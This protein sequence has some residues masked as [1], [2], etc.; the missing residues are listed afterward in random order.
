MFLSMNDVFKDISKPFNLFSSVDTVSSDF[1]EKV[2]NKKKRTIPSEEIDQ[3]AFRKEKECI[4]TKTRTG[5]SSHVILEQMIVM[6]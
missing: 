5:E 2:V 3:C 6:P 1:Q 4:R